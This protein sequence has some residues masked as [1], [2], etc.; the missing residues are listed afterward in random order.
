LKAE[1]LRLRPLRLDDFPFLLVETDPLIWEA[2]RVWGFLS[3][4]AKKH[5]LKIE[6]TKTVAGD[7]VYQI[8][9]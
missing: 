7:R 4:G 1:L 3:T 2:H 6:S 9:K 5:S 8:K